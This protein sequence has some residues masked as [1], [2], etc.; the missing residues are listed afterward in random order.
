MKLSKTHLGST[1]AILAGFL[2]GFLGF[3]S[4]RIMQEGIS[5]PNM[6]F[7]R[8]AISALFILPFIFFK[9]KFNK[10]SP[11]ELFKALFFG[12]AFYCLSPIFFCI[13]SRYI[14]TGLSMVIFFIYPL[15]VMFINWLLYKKKISR[16]YYLAIIIILS[17]MILLVDLSAMHFN[18]L[19]I[20]FSVLSGAFYAFYIVG[21]SK[22][23]KIEP[24][25]S[26]FM[27][28]LGCAF[29]SIL[30]AFSDG[31]F[32]VPMSISLWLYF[33]GY[34]IICTSIPILIFLE[35]IK[36]ISSEQASI[37]SVLEPVFV[38]IFGV[39]LLGEVLNGWQGL[40]VFAILAGA[41]IVLIDKKT[42][43][44]KD[45]DNLYFNP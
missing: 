28:S 37:L 30:F 33:L 35:S 42:S 43:A 45:P 3:F 5:I 25:I 34:G 32:K 31:S 4:V 20:L 16:I 22:L 1:Y 11:K 19:G 38:V 29:T 40:G 2:Y 18:L 12:A 26:T 10:N 13:S 39:I 41:V 23:S 8:F 9:K 24:L 17:G 27:V 6:M 7:W 15:I 44:K 21:S 14:S 36:F